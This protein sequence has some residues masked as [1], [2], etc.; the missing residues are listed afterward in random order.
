MILWCTEGRAERCKSARQIRGPVGIDMREREKK[1]N[2]TSQRKKERK[3]VRRLEHM[4][5]A[6]H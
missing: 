6:R 3:A 1:S 4:T 5:L 2:D